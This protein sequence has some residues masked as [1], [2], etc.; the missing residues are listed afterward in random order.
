MQLYSNCKSTVITIKKLNISSFTFSFFLYS[1][2]Q[3]IPYNPTK[4]CFMQ[5]KS[6]CNTTRSSKA[7]TPNTNT[8]NKEDKQCKYKYLMWDF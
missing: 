7:T 4:L 6:S 1:R 2:L 5:Q 8:N 3:I